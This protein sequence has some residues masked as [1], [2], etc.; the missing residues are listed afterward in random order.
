MTSITFPGTSIGAQNARGDLR[1][2]R[3]EVEVDVLLGT[4]VDAEL[5]QRRFE[6]REHPVRRIEPVELGRAEQPRDVPR[7]RVVES[8]IPSR[9]RNRSSP[10]R[11]HSF[12][13]SSSSSRTRRRARRGGSR[14]ACRARSSWASRAC[15]PRRGRSR[16][17][18]DTPGSGA[19]RAAASASSSSR[20]RVS[21]S[22]SFDM[23]TRIIRYGMRL[24]V[25]RRSQLCL[26]LRDARLV[27]ARQVAEEALAG[28]APE[29]GRCA[30]P[31]SAPSRASSAPRTR[32]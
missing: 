24:A 32:S 8:P 22:G 7:S 25:H 31:G 28:K 15:A 2:P 29:L 19:R 16:P 30:S 21:R 5:G 6:R 17:L 18:R 9:A 1:R 10:S 23:T 4:Q 20:R 14:S 3:L 11:S 26:D 13:V 27:L 12:S